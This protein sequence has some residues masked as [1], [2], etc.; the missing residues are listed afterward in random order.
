MRVGR[1]EEGRGR[2]GGRRGG[3]R[4]G[5]E[6]ERGRE[7]GVGGGEGR[8]EERMR[9]EGEAV[10]FLSF[11]S[12]QAVLTPQHL[13]TFPSLPPFL[14]PP[15]PPPSPLAGQEYGTSDKLLLVACEDGAACVYDVGA[16]ILVSSL[17]NCPAYCRVRV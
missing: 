11:Y 6:E 5:W 9:G 13:V 14:T 12:L 10:S 7:D 2:R 8:E 4:M 15:P 1:G 16:R 17:D 3:G